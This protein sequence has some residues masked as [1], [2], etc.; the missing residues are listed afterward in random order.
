MGKAIKPGDLLDIVLADGTSIRCH[1][2]S[3]REFRDLTGVTNEL[4]ERGQGGGTLQT[5]DIDL[6]LTA[7][8]LILSDETIDINEDLTFP[9]M[10]ELVQVYTTRAAAGPDTDEKKDSGPPSRSD[11]AKSVDPVSTA[12][13]KN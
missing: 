6:M 7:A 4:I 12:N 13:V 1:H 11:S 10:M 2:L 3:V 9:Q 8:D 5:T